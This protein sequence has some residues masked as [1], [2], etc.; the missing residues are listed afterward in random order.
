MSVSSALKM[1]YSS[2]NTHKEYGEGGVVFYVMFL[3]L[4]IFFRSVYAFPVCMLAVGFLSQETFVKEIF[5]S[6]KVQLYW[7]NER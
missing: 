7:L 2:N 4:I 6:L 3:Y 1:T 5:K